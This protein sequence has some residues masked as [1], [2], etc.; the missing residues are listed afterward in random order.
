MWLLSMTSRRPMIT[1]KYRKLQHFKK[2]GYPKISDDPRFFEGVGVVV[3]INNKTIE[4]IV[5]DDHRVFLVNVTRWVPY[6]IPYSLLHFNY[7][8]ISLA[9]NNNKTRENV[10]NRF[11]MIFMSLVLQR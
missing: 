5:I 1:Q 9:F 3:F 10:L 8:E 4:F 7:I 11:I 6:K 2:C